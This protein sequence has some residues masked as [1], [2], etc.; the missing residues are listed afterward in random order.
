MTVEN[1][2][3]SISTKEC[4]RPRQGLNP[5]PP[6]LQVDGASN[7]ATEASSNM[8][9]GPVTWEY[10]SIKGC[11]ETAFTQPDQSFGCRVNRIIS[12]CRINW[13]WK[14]PGKIVW[15][16]PSPIIYTQ[17]S[18]EPAHDKIYN[19]TSVNSEDSDQPVHPCSLIR[20]LNDHM[21]FLQTPGYL[22]RDRWKSLSYWVTVHADLSLL[23]TQ[24]LLQVLSCAGLFSN[25]A[26]Y[27]SSSISHG[28]T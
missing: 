20:V 25:V 9:K 27:L 11:D 4:Y 18:F 22:K 28:K 14:G 1:I 8:R 19:K 2:S 26:I 10:V 13:K 21:P 16:G 7:W 15:S 3:W 23:V 24:V 17:W 5:R 12:Y 6:G